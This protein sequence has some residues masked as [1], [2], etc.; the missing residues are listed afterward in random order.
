MKKLGT[1]LLILSVGLFTIGTVGC[2]GA[3]DKDKPAA[4]DTPAKDTPAKDAP[5]KDAPAKDAPEK[6]KPAS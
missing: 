2:G 5:A 6:D 3:K 1:L 4:K